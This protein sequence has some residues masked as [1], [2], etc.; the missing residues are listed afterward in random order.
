MEDSG[1]WTTPGWEVGDTRY[2]GIWSNCHLFLVMQIIFWFDSGLEEMRGK[3]Q[4]IRD[5]LLFIDSF[6][7][8]CKRHILW[9]WPM[10]EWSERKQTAKRGILYPEAENCVDW[11]SF[12]LKS[13]SVEKAL[14]C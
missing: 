5:F 13:C 11:E 2:A 4:Y 10:W 1:N 9:M 12:N 3:I 8:F 6:M 14:Q 7:R